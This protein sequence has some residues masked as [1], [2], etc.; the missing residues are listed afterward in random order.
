MKNL[1]NES[2]NFITRQINIGHLT[3]KYSSIAIAK[4]ISSLVMVPDETNE[5]E[6]YY[7][8]NVLSAVNRYMNRLISLA[9]IDLKLV[10]FY[11]RIFVLARYY[12]YKGNT[13][14][15]MTTVDNAMLNFLSVDKVIDMDTMNIIRNN[16]VEISGIHNGIIKILKEF[17]ATNPLIIQNTALNK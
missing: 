3:S 10:S 12:A 8:E 11:T 7:R 1:T 4:A 13:F 15:Y 5:P 9:T 14:L 2:F 6:V 17:D 16:A